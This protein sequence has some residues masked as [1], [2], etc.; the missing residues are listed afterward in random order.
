[1]SS[2]LRVTVVRS[3]RKSRAPVFW[4]FRTPLMASALSVLMQLTLHLLNTSKLPAS[5]G[6]TKKMD[7]GFHEVWGFRQG[8]EPSPSEKK[9]PD[10]RTAPY[11]ESCPAKLPSSAI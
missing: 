4:S 5:R 10:H 2:F 8:D 11:I 1:M 7:V 6:G 9:H 3:R